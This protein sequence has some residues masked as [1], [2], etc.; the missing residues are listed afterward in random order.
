MDIKDKIE[1]IIE[2]IKNDKGF[3]DRFKIN[4]VKEIETLFGVD[5]PDEMI[6]NILTGVKAKLTS[7]KAGELFDNIKNLF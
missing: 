5:L 2:K 3:A 6:N 1:E 4:P 7:D